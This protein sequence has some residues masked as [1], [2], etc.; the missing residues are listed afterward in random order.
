[1]SCDPPLIQLYSTGFNWVTLFNW[2][3]REKIFSLYLLAEVSVIVPTTVNEPEISADP[4]Y[5]KGLTD[6][7]APSTNKSPTTFKEPVITA[8][9][10]VTELPEC[11]KLPV[12]CWISLAS[13]PKIL[14]PEVI[15]VEEDSKIWYT[16]V[17][18][19]AVTVVAKISLKDTEE[20]VDT[21]CPIETVVPITVTPVPAT[22]AT[23]VK[24]EPQP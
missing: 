2:F 24:P 17:P 6:N 15:I 1:M 20:V 3:S 5:G 13:F 16:K 7:G 14:E 18:V 11:N 9:P 10:V 19:A 8:D 22:G 12:I 23:S 21:S 4:V